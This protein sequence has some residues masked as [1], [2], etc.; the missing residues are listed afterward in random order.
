MLGELG[1]TD[2]ATSAPNFAKEVAVDDVFWSEQGAAL[3][4]RFTAWIAK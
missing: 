1:S 2:A 3:E 4:A